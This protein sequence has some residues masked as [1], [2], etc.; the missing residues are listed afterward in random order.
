MIQSIAVEDNP[1]LNK[2]ILIVDDYPPTRNLLRDALNQ[3]GYYGIDEAENGMD[4]LSKCRHSPFDL[5]IS[6]VMMPAMGGMELLYQLR[7]VSPSTSVIMITSHPAT[8]LTVSAM[9]NGAVDFLKK[10][11]NIDEL[12]FKVRIYLNEKTLLEEIKPAV[13]VAEIQ[14]KDITKGLSVQEFIYDSF[15]DVEGDNEHIF[16]KI[17]DLS[18]N[19]VDGEE[20]SLILFDGENNAFHPKI[21]K[22]FDREAYE[23][24]TIPAL[25]QIFH[26]VV[27]RKE[28]MMISSSEHPEIAP[29]LI[30]APMMI[31]GNV[32][33]ILSV[34]KKINRELFTTKDLHYIVSLTKRASLNLENRILYE[35]VYSNVLDTFKSLIDSIQVRDYYTE[36]HSAR[37]TRMS[38]KIAEAM[39]CTKKEI[40]SLKI[41]AMLHDVG[42][43]AIPDNVLLKPDRLTV[44]EFAVIKTHPEVGERILKPILLLDQE[45]EIILHHHERWDGKGYPEGLA[46]SDIP[47]LSRVI[48]VADSF[49]A[50]TNTRPYR[51]AMGVNDAVAEL[52]RN[53]NTQF[54]EQVVD[55]LLTTL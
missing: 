49:D 17:V 25:K 35:S 5:V 1:G 31:R 6:D 8:E 50:M 19:V 16:E 38:V 13:G 18:L 20:C 46:G 30:C 9:K 27:A 33:G 44:E 43:I 40:E 45:R 55:A 7:E 51:Q 24:K 3:E 29:S 34:R 48:A 54:D 21:I 14:L 4:A 26:E 52:E 28:A 2:K 12:L 23:T 36:E 41:S 39:H 32:F 53:R 11:F 42:K 22:S 15:E 37:V 47:L 10:P